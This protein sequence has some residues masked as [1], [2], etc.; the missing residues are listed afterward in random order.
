MSCNINDS[1]KQK[2]ATNNQW[3]QSSKVGS[4]SDYREKTAT[5]NQWVSMNKN[6]ISSPE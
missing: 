1:P 2:S 6:A 5:D 4:S 3:Q